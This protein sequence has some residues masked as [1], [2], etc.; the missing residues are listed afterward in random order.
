MH[1]SYAHA[2]GCKLVSQQCLASTGGKNAHVTSVTDYPNLT[3]LGI[4]NLV[5]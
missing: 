5:T 4:V 3:V 2:E 1:G